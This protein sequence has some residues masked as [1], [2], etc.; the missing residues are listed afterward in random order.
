MKKSIGIIYTAV[1]MTA[2]CVPFAAA[3]ISPASETTGKEDAA[4]MPELFSDGRLN[5]RIGTEFDDYFTKSVP[6]RP[7][8]ITAQNTLSGALLGKENNNVLTGKKGWLF[9]GESTDEFIGVRKSDRSIH[10]AAETIRIMQECV[11]AKGMNFVFTVAPD[12]NE[13]YPEYM[14]SG[15]IK[16]DENTLSVLEKYLKDD[17][18]N[19]VS[20]K[21]ELLSVKDNGAFLYLT[22]DTHWNGLGALYGYNAIMKGLGESYESFSGTEYSVRND[23][24]GDIAK[25]AYPAAAP[26]CSQYYF[27]LDY[28]K[29]R[30]LQPR[31]ASSNDKLLEE[32]M[33]DAAEAGLSLKLSCGYV[34]AE[35]QHQQYSAEVSRL[36]AEESMTAKNAAAQAEKTIPA[37]NC[38]ELQS[39]LAVKFSQGSSGDFSA[40]REYFWLTANSAKYGFILR[41]PEG[42]EKSTGFDYDPAHF[43]FVGK[44]NANKIKTLN[45][46][47]EEY[48]AYLAARSE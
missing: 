45:M 35:V 16:S 9:S 22:G 33:S 32:L 18:I 2:C 26:A 27:D 38:S 5:D 42:R 36:Q 6:F 46:T 12:K 19:Y 23:W 7:Q 28:S 39:G 37:E 15:F 31:A 3:I 25:M 13:I 47:L 34:S 20:L 21:D 8:I 1:F 41:Y 11:T 4:K 43:R 14:P 40:S 30:F 10:N 44:E 17:K 48:N 29:L 24:Y